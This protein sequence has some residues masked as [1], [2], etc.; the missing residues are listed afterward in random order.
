MS[1][2]IEAPLPLLAL[3]YLTILKPILYYE[4]KSAT[5]LYHRLAIGSLKSDK[6]M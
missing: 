3:V 6:T 4:F 5:F 1:F 2:R